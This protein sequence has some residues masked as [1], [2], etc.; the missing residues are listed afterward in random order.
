MRAIDC[1]YQI[2][3][4]EEEIQDCGLCAEEVRTRA[5][6]IVAPMDKERVQSSGDS[7]RVGTACARIVDLERKQIELLERLEAIKSVCLS[8]ISEIDNENY[9]KILVGKYFKG[10]SMY[11]LSK[12]IGI[13][14]RST[15]RAHKIAL[16][17]FVTIYDTRYAENLTDT[18]K[19]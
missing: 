8:C 14:Y 17:R 3:Y 1:L 5:C 18:N 11:Q 10:K 12:E 7:D 16:E 6:N 2:R 15:K 4:I 9:R 13:L 19:M